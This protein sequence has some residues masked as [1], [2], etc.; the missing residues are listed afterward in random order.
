MPEDV[1]LAIIVNPALPLGLIGNTVAAIAI[2]VGARV[3]DLGARSLRDRAERRIDISSEKPV[4]ILQADAGVLRALM[5]KALADPLRQAVVPF[6]AF[7]R[8]LHDYADYE[9]QLPERDLAEEAIDGLGLA[10]PAKWVRS[11]TG[12]LKLLR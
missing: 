10:G 2:G 1:R 7:A 5:L 6:P 11:L 4:P 8:A 3:P 12:A 9:A